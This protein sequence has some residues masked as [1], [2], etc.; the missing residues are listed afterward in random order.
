MKNRSWVTWLS[1]VSAVCLLVGGVI[2]YIGFTNREPDTPFPFYAHEFSKEYSYDE[3]QSIQ[4]D[5]NAILF[6]VTTGN[7]NKIV[8]RNIEDERVNVHNEDGHLT[9]ALHQKRKLKKQEIAIVVKE[10]SIDTLDISID[11][12]KIL[13]QD[14]T[15]KHLTMD[16]KATRVDMDHTTITNQTTLYA[17]AGSYVFNNVISNQM[18]LQLDAGSIEFHGELKGKSKLDVRAGSVNLMLKD[19]KENYGY[20]VENKAGSVT[21]DGKKIKGFSNSVTHQEDADQLLQ[22]YTSAGSV[23]IAFNQ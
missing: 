8:I 5:A 17:N 1:I 12:G 6:S 7:E 10:G 19:A 22:V 11:A 20:Q 15:I 4:V 3:I 13:L 14:L 9:I 16:N 23:R 21:I 18:H 2:F